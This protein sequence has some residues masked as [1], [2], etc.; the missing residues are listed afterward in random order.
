MHPWDG[1]AAKRSRLN[2]LSPMPL[3]SVAFSHRNSQATMASSGHS[4]PAR[5]HYL[6][7]GCF[8]ISTKKNTD[9]NSISC[10]RQRACL[11]M[12]VF[13]EK[14]SSVFIVFL[15]SLVSLQCPSP[16]LPITVSHRSHSCP[17]DIALPGLQMLTGVSKLC[18]SAQSPGGPG[19]STLC[20]SLCHLL[21]LA[22]CSWHRLRTIPLGGAVKSGL[23]PS[24][25]NLHVHFIHVH[26]PSPPQPPSCRFGSYWGG[27]DGRS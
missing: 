21:S 19:L 27:H 12:F 4:C 5:N 14:F 6:E 20:W 24:K 15:A 16:H 11:L 25:S 2:L 8:S 7:G 26:G 23:V 1:R 3:S 10:V 22:S 17:A 13:L 18:N 9:F